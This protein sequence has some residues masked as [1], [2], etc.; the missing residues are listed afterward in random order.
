VGGTWTA[1]SAVL[2]DQ[3]VG[4]FGSERARDAEVDVDP[5]EPPGPSRRTEDRCYRK[6]PQVFLRNSGPDVTPERI[7]ESIVACVLVAFTI[8]WP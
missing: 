5:G 6:N 8:A 1:A 2:P 3:A 7:G 4:V